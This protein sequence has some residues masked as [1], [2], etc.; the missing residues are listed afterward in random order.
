MGKSA[1]ATMEFDV[2]GEFA[3]SFLQH[4]TVKCLEY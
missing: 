4:Y 3:F 2:L 1:S